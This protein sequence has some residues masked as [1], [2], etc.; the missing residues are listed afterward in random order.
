MDDLQ[1]IL[2]AAKQLSPDEQ[3]KLI[4]KVSQSL[5]A[6]HQPEQWRGQGGEFAPAATIPAGIRRTEPVKDLAHLRADFWPDDESADDINTFIA[7]QRR[8]DLLIE[9]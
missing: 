3:L 9:K 5:Q 4:E 2:E 7:A 6:R 8:E 1:T